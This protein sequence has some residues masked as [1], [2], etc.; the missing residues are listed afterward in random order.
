MRLRKP[1]PDAFSDSAWPGQR[2][3]AG[4]LR[5]TWSTCWPQPAHVVLPQVLQVAARHMVVSPQVPVI[6]IG[7][8]SRLTIADA[9]RLAK[10]GTPSESL[11]VNTPVGIAPIDKEGA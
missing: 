10:P 3:P 11:S 6:P 2:W 4:T 7:V 1:G 8:C 9:G 5:M